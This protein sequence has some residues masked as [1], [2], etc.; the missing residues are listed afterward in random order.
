MATPQQGGTPQQKAAVSSAKNILAGANKFEK[1]ADP[2]G[3]LKPKDSAGV[4]K[5]TKTVSPQTDSAGVKNLN[6]GP[7]SPSQ[8]SGSVADTNRSVAAEE[9]AKYGVKSMPIMHKGGV[10]KADGPH[11]LQKGEIVIPASGRQSEYREAFEERGRQGL[12]KYGQAAKEQTR[13]VGGNT[14]AKGEEQLKGAEKIA[15]PTKE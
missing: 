15:N 4:S 11:M 5:M 1:S 7:M 10:V 9:G 2:T 3:A 6:K 8:H 14:P 13:Q 12:H